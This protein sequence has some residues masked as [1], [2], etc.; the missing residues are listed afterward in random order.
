[1]AKHYRFGLQ[2]CVH[3]WSTCFRL[4][5]MFIWKTGLVALGMSGLCALEVSFALHIVHSVTLLVIQC[6]SAIQ[7]IRTSSGQKFHL[8]INLLRYQVIQ[9][10]C[11][12]SKRK[13]RTLHPPPAKGSANL[14]QDKK[15]PTKISVKPSKHYGRWKQ[16]QL[17]ASCVSGLTFHKAERALNSV[18]LLDYKAQIHSFREASSYSAPYIDLFE[19]QKK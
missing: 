9:A 13:A 11:L 2:A 6:I 17:K 5:K 18:Q 8:E 1:M 4:Q 19:Q 10:N 16:G 7:K 15:K 14:K 12:L 3:T